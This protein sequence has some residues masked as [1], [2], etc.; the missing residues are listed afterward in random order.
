MYCINLCQ[1]TNRCALPQRNRKRK[2][3]RILNDQSFNDS[4]DILMFF[5]K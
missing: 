2:R 3:T 1:E 4:R 5:D